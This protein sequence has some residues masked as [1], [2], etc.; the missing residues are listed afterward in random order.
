[1]DDFPKIGLGLGCDLSAQWSVGKVIN[2]G[3]RKIC[4]AARVGCAGG[5]HEENVATRQLDDRHGLI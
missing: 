4:D 5:G 2:E 3:A 1:M